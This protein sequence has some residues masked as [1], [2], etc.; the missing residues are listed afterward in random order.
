MLQT[1]SQ[2]KSKKR[3]ITKRIWNS[4]ATA[5]R[6][7]KIFTLE[8]PWINGKHDQ[9]EYSNAAVGQHGRRQ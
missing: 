9:Q 3:K 2:K 5:I 8:W 6:I 1:L 4:M 7:L